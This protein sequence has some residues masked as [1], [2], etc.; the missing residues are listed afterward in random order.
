VSLLDD[1]IHEF[2]FHGQDAL[3]L[4]LYALALIYTMLGIANLSV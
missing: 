3:V 1:V 4:Q 2:G